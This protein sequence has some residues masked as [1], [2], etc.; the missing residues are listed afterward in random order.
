MEIIWIMKIII[1]FFFYTNALSTKVLN[2]GYIYYLDMAEAVSIKKVY[3]ELKNIEKKM[4]TKK[5]I[6][7]LIETIGIMSNPETMK[8]IAESMEDI[9]QGRIKEVNSVKDLMRE[10]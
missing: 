2:M 1:F 5:E 9:K 3:E 8:Q 6:E 7:S 4:V 10:I